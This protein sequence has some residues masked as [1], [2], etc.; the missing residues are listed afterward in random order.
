VVCRGLPLSWAGGCA[1]VHG[2]SIRWRVGGVG[3]GRQVLLVSAGGCWVGQRG[4]RGVANRLVNEC[5]PLWLRFACAAHVLIKEVLRLPRMPPGTDAEGQPATRCLPEAEHP[6]AQHAIS[7]RRRGP[8]LPAAAASMIRWA[9]VD[10]AIGCQTPQ[11]AR[12]E[13]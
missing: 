13:L 6:G 7:L 3:A 11:I 9:G 5:G 2:A 12:V 10:G 1:D 8:A 4:D